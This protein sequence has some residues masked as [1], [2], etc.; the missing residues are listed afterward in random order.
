MSNC[1]KSSGNQGVFIGHSSKPIYDQCAYS[2]YTKR[3]TDPLNYRLNPE[4]IYNCKQCV[5]VFGP[6][7]ASFGNST[8]VGNVVAPKQQLV[9]IDS[10]LSNRN[11]PLSRC[12]DAGVNDINPTKFRLQHAN[13]CNDFL[14]PVPTH[15]TDPPQNYRGMAI[16]RFTCL[17][18]DPQANIFWDHAINSS[19]AS[20]DN[21]RQYV[22]ASIAGD[23]LPQPTPGKGKTCLYN[24][25]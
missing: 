1:N 14:D 3:S 17:P 24:C 19:L 23:V 13:V 20:K 22:P 15:L 18:K 8:S 11:V 6:R 10:I 2:D 25:K 5:S 16:D 12:P 21:T 9:D 4:Q 7:G